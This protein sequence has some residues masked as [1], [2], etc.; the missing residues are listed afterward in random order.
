MSL[1]SRKTIRT[2]CILHNHMLFGMI[3]SLLH[4]CSENIK[5][6]PPPR[7]MKFQSGMIFLWGNKSPYFPHYHV[8]NV[9]FKLILAMYLATNI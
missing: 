1:K 2:R 6:T 4:E 3:K 5:I 7:K 9:C 8:R